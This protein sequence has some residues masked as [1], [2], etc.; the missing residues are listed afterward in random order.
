[1]DGKA[2]TLSA[3]LII[4]RLLHVN[5]EHLY[6]HNYS[7]LFISEEILIGSDGCYR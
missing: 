3:I 1:M 4:I 5:N 6:E 2:V 7:A